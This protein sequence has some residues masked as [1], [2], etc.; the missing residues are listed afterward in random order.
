MKNFIFLPGTHFSNNETKK[1]FFI[2]LKGLLSFLELYNLDH[3]SLCELVSLFL[4]HFAQ[5]LPEK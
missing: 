5:I 1:G 3:T 4:D 2:Y